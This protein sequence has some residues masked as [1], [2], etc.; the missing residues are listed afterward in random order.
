[1]V[2][3][4]GGVQLLSRAVNLL[5][6]LPIGYLS[7]H[8][9]TRWGRRLPYVLGASL[10]LPGLFLLLWRPPVARESG[11][12]LAYVGFILL[13]FNLA[14]S[15]RQ[16]PLEAL[17][18]EIAP[19]NEQ[20]VGIAAWQSGFQILGVVLTGFVGPFIDKVGYQA[21]AVLYAVF[22]LFCS[23]LPFLVLRERPNVQVT[24]VARLDF[25]K[26]TAITLKNKPFQVF[27]ISWGLFWFA[28]TLMLEVVPYIVTEI[29]QQPEANAIY[30]Y[31]PPVVVS[32]ICYPLVTKLS[33]R[34]GKKLVFFTSLLAS[35]LIL[36]LLTFIGEW[37][38][39]PLLAQGMLW[40][41]LLTAAMTGAQVLPAA[42][43]A[44]VTDYDRETTGQ[45]RE[46]SYYAMWGVFDQLCSGLAVSLLPL[47]LLLGRSQTDLHGPLG[48]R[49]VGV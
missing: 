14:Y 4:F 37:L 6:T 7:D 25:W 26:S 20:R 42:I 16:I 19:K 3:L 27:L 47:L 49:M 38:P 33:L 10:L 17:L 12:N 36:P 41:T 13:L 15:L 24:T 1:S 29:C 40:M 34:R 28:S 18:P 44:D 35:G 22:A 48:I 45:R 23:L 30:F 5:L 8:T 43:T 11:W 46:G 39:I 21:M 32:L 9:R 2:A 31:L